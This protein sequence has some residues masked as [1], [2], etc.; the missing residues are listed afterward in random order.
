MPVRRARMSDLLEMQNCNLANLPENY[1]MKY[2]IYHAFCWPQLLY[3]NVDHEDRMR[4]YVMAKTEEEEVNS[5]NHGHITSLAVL[6]S[7]RKLG[8][9]GSLVRQSRREVEKSFGGE[10]MSLHVRVTNESAVMLYHK[11]LGFKVHGIDKQYYGDNEDAYDMKWLFQHDPYGAAVKRCSRSQDHDGLLEWPE[12]NEE[13]KKKID[14]YLTEKERERLRKNA[15][16]FR[17]QVSADKVAAADDDK[18]DD[19]KA[20]NKRN[21]NKKRR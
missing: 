1:Q 14:E 18:A 19:K 20:G 17:T 8:I 9:A 13:G 10:Y 3:V 16:G 7:S 5:I 11:G 2:Y 15:V 12:G 6:K 21:K 4:G